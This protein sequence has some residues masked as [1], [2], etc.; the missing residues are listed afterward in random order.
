MEPFSFVSSSSSD[1]EAG[2]GA[3]YAHPRHPTPPSPRSSAGGVAKS[4]T[5]KYRFFCV[6][7][8]G[9]PHH[10]LD[11]CFLCRKP[12]AGNRDIFMYRSLASSSSSSSSFYPLMGT[13]VAGVACRGDTPF[14]S[15]ECRLVQIEMDEGAEH[16]RKHSLKASSTT[17]SNKAGAATGPSKSHEAHARTGANAESHAMR[18]E[19]C[20][21]VSVEWGHSV[22]VTQ[23]STRQANPTSF[24]DVSSS[25]SVLLPSLLTKRRCRLFS[26]FLVWGRCV[27]RF[28]W[29]GFNKNGVFDVCLSSLKRSGN[30][31]GGRSYNR[32]FRSKRCAMDDEKCM[33]QG[34]PDADR[35]GR[36]TGLQQGSSPS[37]SPQPPWQVMHKAENKYEVGKIADKEEAKQRRVRAILNKLTPKNFT[38]LFAQI[39]GVNID[40]ALTLSGVV[41]QIFN[42]A[43]MEPTF[44]EVYANFCVHLAAELPTFSEGISFKRLLL[45]A[46]QEEFERRER[47]EAEGGKVEMQQQTN[48]EREARRLLARMRGLGNVRLIGELYKARMLT[49]RIMHECIKKLLGQHQN[50]EEEDVEA[51]C[52]LL[53]VIG[54]TIDHPKAKE[55]MDAYF[56]IMAKLS[57][58]QK[59]SLRVRFMLRDAIDLRKNKWQARRLMLV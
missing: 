33:A 23:S 37:P 45:N 14:C 17:D 41:S 43:L 58:N 49:E 1:L 24:Q 39:R 50:P 34:R 8:D 20:S 31:H 46:C 5:P 13:D 11:S 38:R 27:H 12:L 40:N 10:F 54:K 30:S 29:N 59:L 26:V 44:C 48:G 4:R 47:E 15:E 53:G 42:K 6:D 22:D 32:E 3:P 9:P 52:R 7:V 36:E 51:V 19:D 57:T 21:R 2:W 28:G 56:D 16:S 18:T 25:S 55:Y 35:S